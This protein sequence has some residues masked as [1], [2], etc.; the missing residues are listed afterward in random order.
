MDRTQEHDF[1]EENVE[2]V[3]AWEYVH[4]FFCARKAL[5]PCRI[6]ERLGVPS[7]Y[8]QEEVNSAA[9]HM[10]QKM[11]HKQYAIIEDEE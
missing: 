3:L 2:R 6:A 7:S 11:V 9:K 5:R 10:K 1:I 8:I 4:G